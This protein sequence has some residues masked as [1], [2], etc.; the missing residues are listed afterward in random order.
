[1]M[2]VVRMVMGVFLTGVWK[3]MDVMGGDDGCW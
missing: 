3:V 1:M 2:G